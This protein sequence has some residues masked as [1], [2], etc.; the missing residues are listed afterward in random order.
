MNGA[1]MRP[2][3]EGGTR[4]ASTNLSVPLLMPLCRA[5]TCTSPGPGSRSGSDRISARP[6]AAY[7]KASVV[8][9]VIFFGPNLGLC[10]RPQG[11]IPNSR[12][13]HWGASAVL[14]Q[15]TEV[16]VGV[17]GPITTV[18][19]HRRA[20]FAAL[21]G[22]TTAAVLWLAAVAVA[23]SSAVGLAF[24]VL[25]TI[26]LP[27]AVVGFWN[28][29]IGFLVMRVSDNPAAAVNPLMASI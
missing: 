3:S 24:L 13:P 4:P 7:H 12:T 15:V 14:D 20:L 1:R 29:V 19:A 18:L 9:P 17:E 10:I 2:N 23:P 5:R 16:S 27:W 28:A 25:F 11:Y 22:A 8:R 6:A 26:T 21:V